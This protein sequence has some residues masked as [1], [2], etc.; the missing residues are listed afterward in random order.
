MNKCVFVCL[1]VHFVS[2]LNAYVQERGCCLNSNYNNL[3]FVPQFFPLFAP[4]IGCT[5]FIT[6]HEWLLNLLWRDLDV[7]LFPVEKAKQWNHK[8]K[9]KTFVSLFLSLLWQCLP[10][11][12]SK[13]LGLGIMLLNTIY[14]TTHWSFLNVCTVDSSR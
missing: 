9:N 10:M 12:S 13:E 5:S 8:P 3:Q 1:R 14:R 11:S 2:S 7:N 6:S 4:K